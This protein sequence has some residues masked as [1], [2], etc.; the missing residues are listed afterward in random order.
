MIAAFAHCTGTS[1]KTE[2]REFRFGFK[3]G[4]GG[5]LMLATIDSIDRPPCDKAAI[6]KP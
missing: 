3:P 1:C 4:R 5:E 6:P 2:G